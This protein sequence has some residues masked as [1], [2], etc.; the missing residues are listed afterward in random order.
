MDDLMAEFASEVREGYAALTPQL[1]LW[2]KKPQDKALV[3]S[4]MRH[5]HTAKGGAGFVKMARIEQL[6]AAAEQALSDLAHW[7]LHD[8][9]PQVALIITALARIDG[10]AAAVELG[11]GYPTLGEDA[12]IADLTGQPAP[13][14]NAELPYDPQQI[15]SIRLPLSVLDALIADTERLD[16]RLIALGDAPLPAALAIMRNDMRDTLKKLHGLRFAPLSQLYLGLEHYVEELATLHNQ[17]F[18][19]VTDDGGLLVDRALIPLLRNALTH[20]IRN[21]VAHGIEPAHLRVQRGKPEC[22][23]ITITAQKR[24]DSLC[25]SV[26]DDGGGV[27]YKALVSHAEVNAYAHLDLLA[28]AQQPGIST[29]KNVSSLAGRGMGLDAVRIALERIDGT[30][31]LYDRPELGF[32]AHLIIPTT[33]T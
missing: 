29:A 17:T 23:T 25:L 11:F 26:S 9:A 7:D 15:C 22:G 19:L 10:I 2:R 18:R 27:D 14:V 32:S 31:E 13:L 20:L 24:A 33:R 12:L 3:A 5:L 6:S 1:R 28:F 8:D 16:H 30:L 21:A 4:I